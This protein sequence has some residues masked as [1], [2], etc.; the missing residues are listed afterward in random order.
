[1]SFVKVLLKL[2]DNVSIGIYDSQISLG[3]FLVLWLFIFTWRN[4]YLQENDKNIQLNI[5]KTFTQ[6]YSVFHFENFETVPWY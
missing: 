2:W 4:F 6:K 3:N 1:M 5:N